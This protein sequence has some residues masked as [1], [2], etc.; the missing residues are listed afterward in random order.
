MSKAASRQTNFEASAQGGWQP[1]P[2][3]I[4]LGQIVHTCA[5]Q[6]RLVGWRVV[7]IALVMVLV[8]SAVLGLPQS[9]ATANG[10]GAGSFDWATKAGGTSIDVATGVSV[11]ADGSAIVTGYF[12]GTAKFSGLPDLVSAGKEDVFVA[13]IGAGGVWLWATRAGGTGFDAGN[14][15]SVL[16]DGSAIV[17]G[18]FSGTAK[19]GGLA[20]LVSAGGDEVFV[21]KIRADGV[22]QWATRAGGTGSAAGYGVSVLADGSAIVTGTFKGTASF[23]PSSLVSAGSEDVFVAKIDAGGV[24]LWA[25]R[26]GGSELD[27]GLGVSVLADG[28][29]IVTGRF[30]GTASFTT[31]PTTN[32]ESAGSNN[33]DVFVAKIGA[34]GVWLWATQAGGI[35]SDAGSG[36]S[37]SADGSAIVTGLFSDTAKFSGLPD[38]VSAGSN[39]VFVAKI[40]AGGVWSWATRAGDT[41]FDMGSGVSVLADGSA[42]VTGLFSDTASFAATKL[43][44]AGSEDVFVAKID[45]GGVWLWATRAGGTG[46][47]GG[48][49]VSVLADGSAIVTGYFSGTATIGARPDLVSAGEYDV[50]V[51][52]RFHSVVVDASAGLDSRLAL[53][54]DRSLLEVGAL[55]TCTVSGGGPG[56]EIFWRAAYNP[57]FAGQGVTLDED[58]VGTFA[59][60]VPTAALGQVVTV[61]LVDWLAPVSIGVPGGPVPTSVPSGGGPVPVWSLV[62]LALAGGLVLRRMTAVGVRG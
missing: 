18:Y 13:K 48:S 14:G 21:A 9:P 52:K 7:G 35:G 27:G 17:T 41:G 38:L 25:T 32:L 62:M 23:A 49:G 5:G 34:G 42:I 46:S 53:V 8:V 6:G 33:N 28:S 12:A 16:A 40:G 24:W 47:D 54:C 30:S 55:V 50:L 31:T 51:A 44:S 4:S 20:D 43:V 2:T 26:A 39:D 22:W 11:L 36:V 37:V 19:F 45:A 60:T 56:I 3:R 29:A 10:A 61:E 58:G 15:V 1:V 57:P 59:F